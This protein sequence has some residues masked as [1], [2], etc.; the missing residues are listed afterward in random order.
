MRVALYRGLTA[1]PSQQESAT[2]NYFL[3]FLART[4]VAAFQII[5]SMV[6]NVRD[7]RRGCS[8]GCIETPCKTLPIYAA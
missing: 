4:E 2:W 1:V 5:P 6:R 3:T 7:F 8:L